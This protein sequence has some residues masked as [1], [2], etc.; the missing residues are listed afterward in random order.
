MKIYLRTLKNMLSKK[1]QVFKNNKVSECFSLAD[2]FMPTQKFFEEISHLSDGEKLIKIY[3]NISQN[4]ISNEAKSR[5]LKIENIFEILCLDDDVYL[6]DFSQ[7]DNL[8]Y[9][10]LIIENS[11]I[12]LEICSYLSLYFLVFLNL[13]EDYLDKSEKV[14]FA[15]P[16]YNKT[17]CISALI[18]KKFYSNINY[19]IAGDNLVNKIDKNGF[20]K[21]PYSACEFSQFIQEFFED[22][23]YVFDAYSSN[24]IFAYESFLEQVEDNSSIVFFSF[25]SPYLTSKESFFEITGKIIKDDKLAVKK[26]YEETAIEMP[27]T[28]NIVDKS[29]S[30]INDNLSLQD[31]LHLLENL[32]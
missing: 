17:A 20:F 25:L 12:Y 16:F 13:Y 7:N 23:G 11:T 27:E 8:S 14:N 30:K 18:F 9:K 31:F 4:T 29:Y 6:V 2:F 15:L 1:I 24:E 26:L 19:I 32:L 5:I 28:L 10:T 22:Y 21:P 3:E